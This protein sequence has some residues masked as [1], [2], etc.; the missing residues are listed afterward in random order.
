VFAATIAAIGAIV[1]LAETRRANLAAHERELGA[2]AEAQRANL[3]A[4]ER[5]RE[6]QAADRYTRAI[7]QLG[8]PG[9]DR[10]D[11]RLGGILPC[12]ASLKTFQMPS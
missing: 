4:D 11:V 1:A 12:S 7:S 8:E 3:A 2:L 5:E 10:M 6:A 9:E